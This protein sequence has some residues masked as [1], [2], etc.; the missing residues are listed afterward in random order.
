MTLHEKLLE[1]MKKVQYLSKDG[2]VEFA[3]TKYK[4]LTEEKITSA[5]RPFLEEL[6]VVIYPIHQEHT[7]AGTL[8]TVNVTYR[9][10]NVEK[11]DDY[12][13][14]VSSGTGV[15]TQDKGV[16]KAMTYAYKY[17]LLR[18]FAIPT[19]EDPDKV[20]T[21]QLDVEEKVR[22]KALETKLLAELERTGYALPTALAKLQVAK[23]DDASE[24]A[25]NEI[26]SKF[27]TLPSREVKTESN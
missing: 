8:S 20:A 27:K 22:K 16:G 17:M 15:D 24:E 12:I 7:R 4:A 26:I 25:I 10:V 5:I 14:V 9:I 13:E 21:T 11:A 19:G 23:L 3:Q 18:T 6:G 2:K 1:I